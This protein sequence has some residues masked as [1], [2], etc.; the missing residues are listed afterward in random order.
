MNIL[1]DTLQINVP[2]DATNQ[3]GF[4]QGTVTI[5]V[6]AALCISRYQIVSGVNF[7]CRPGVTVI[8]AGILC[9]TVGVVFQ[10][11]PPLTITGTYSGTGGACAPSITNEGSINPG[12][13]PGI[14]TFNNL[15]NTSSGEIIIEMKGKNTPGTDYDQVAVTG[16]LTLDGKLRI[17]FLNNYIPTL[18][19]EFTIITCGSHSGN[20]SQIIHPGNNPNAWQVIY[21]NPTQIRL[22]L[23]APLSYKSS[24][25]PSHPVGS[26]SSPTTT[27]NRQGSASHK[28]ARRMPART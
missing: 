2:D 12:L 17:V 3:Q 16:A 19:D 11:E 7:W 21:S 14:L 10:V 24:T 5:A 27:P 8:N 13:S 15:T 22:K 9:F 18:N 25:S 6:V 23:V 1:E 28:S 20:F 26:S 4:D